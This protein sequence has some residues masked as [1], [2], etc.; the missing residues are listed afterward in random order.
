MDL[1]QILKSTENCPCGRT[2]TVDIKAVEIASG[3]VNKVGE[4][5]EKY[6]FPKRILVVSDNN[7]MRVSKGILDNLMAHGFVFDARIY[8]NMRTA[9]IREVKEIEALCPNVDAILAIGTGSVDDICRYAAARQGKR[10][11]IFGTAPSM[12]GYA[13]DSSPITEGAFKL[14]CPAKQPE[15]IIADTKILASAPVELKAAGFGDMIAKCVGL[16]DWRVSNI[17]TGEY[18]CENIAN[19]TREAVRRI[20]SLADK[21]TLEN[22]ESAGAVMEALIFTGI[23]MKMAGTS[24]PASGCEHIISHFWESKKLEEGHISDYHGKKVGV[25]T[26]IVAKTYH[27][28][29]KLESIKA[30]K[31]NLDWQEIRD[32]YGPN[33]SVD[34][35][36]LNTPTV[37]D[38]VDPKLFEEKWPEIR[39]IIKE[40]LPDYDTLVDLFKRAGAVTTI[41]EIAVTPELCAL[42]YKFHPFMRH[43]L[44]IM[45]LRWMFDYPT[46]YKA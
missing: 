45:R 32:A 37:T 39:N 26:L 18:Y 33:L 8:D 4:I 12:D 24:R 6:D 21:I 19:L 31:E 22:E 7:A 17:L 23:A 29:A 40:E 42:A 3:L 41:E 34:M 44:N 36:K 46:D 15:I 2:H 9:D 38:E 30:H 10:F 20:I 1:S 28:M 16:V 27:E 43:R 13:S 35:M 5:L 11:A 25:A 14:T